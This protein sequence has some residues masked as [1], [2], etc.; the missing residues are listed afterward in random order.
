MREVISPAVSKIV[1]TFNSA[2]VNRLNDCVFVAFLFQ[3]PYMRS[4]D[5]FGNHCIVSSFDRISMVH[6]I[7][8]IVDDNSFDCSF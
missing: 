5:N 4:T 3:F 2:C 7:D 1:T 8:V 6:T